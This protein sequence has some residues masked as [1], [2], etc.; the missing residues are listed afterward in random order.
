MKS[1][2]TRLEIS[3]LLEDDLFSKDT[4]LYS[5]SQDVLYLSY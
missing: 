3:V 2:F 5:F 1:I 4:Q